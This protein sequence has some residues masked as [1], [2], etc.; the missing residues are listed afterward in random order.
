MRHN[1]KK[2]VLTASVLAVV[3]CQDLAVENPNAPD[4]ERALNNPEDIETLVASSWIPYWDRTQAKGWPYHALT[5]VSGIHQTSVGNNAALELSVI[6]RPRYDNNPVSKHAGVARYPWYDFYKGLDNANIGLRAIQDGLEIG[7]DGAN[8]HRAISFATFSQGLMLGYIGLMYDKGF[9]A[10]E[11]ADFEDPA[12]LDLHPYEEVIAAAVEKMQEAAEI[13]LQEEFTIPNYWVNGIT[14]SNED[15]AKLAHSFAARFL[16]YSARY[17]EDREDV[18]WE[19][20]IYHVDNG[21]TEDFI[22][23]HNR[24][25]LES[26]NYKRRIQN[27]A[28]NGFFADNW[29]LG[30]ADVSNN[31]QEWL[32][33][34]LEDRRRFHITT[35]DRRLTGEEPDSRG[36]Y[37]TY[38]A[39]HN[40]RDE[41]GT[42]RQSYYQFRRWNGAWRDAP[43]LLMSVDEMNLLKAEA[44]ARLGRLD[45]AAELTNLTRVENGE[46]PPVT[47][48]GVPVSEDCVPRTHEGVCEDLLGAIMWERMIE[49]TGLESP[50]DWM[51]N[52]GWGVL[53]P[54]TFVHL[55]IPGREL[56]MLQIPIYS[57]GGVGG[58]GAAR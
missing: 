41:R 23:E 6:P 13:S 52:R 42:W 49:T 19:R 30:R 48:E 56:E 47:A 17:P 50:L 21:I 27:N 14:L 35:P 3:G 22:L 53:Q 57:F 33:T 58:E 51:D 44:L 5:A 7:K 9:I 25:E 26:P 38:R 11:D 10:F 39:T 2:I 15:L 4:R 1:L 43:T 36:K 55:P 18:D 46:L 45:E 54:G 20:V 37:F 32:D 8:N 16:V 34:P 28:F 29:F 12:T 24:E 40:F 31:F